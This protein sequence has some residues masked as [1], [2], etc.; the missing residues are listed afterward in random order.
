MTKRIQHFGV[1][2]GNNLAVAASGVELKSSLI[3]RMPREAWRL[4]HW[5]IFIGCSRGRGGSGVS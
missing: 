2:I 1:E 5:L 3:L 4:S